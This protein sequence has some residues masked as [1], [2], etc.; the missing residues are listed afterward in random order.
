MLTGVAYERGPS[1]FSLSSGNTYASRQSFSTVCSTLHDQ[2][3][4]SINTGDGYEGW[5]VHTLPTVATALL[6]PVGSCTVGSVRTGQEYQ[7]GGM[8]SEDVEGTDRRKS[9]AQ[10]LLLTEPAL[11]CRLIDQPLRTSW[12]SLKESS[13]A[14]TRCTWIAFETWISSNT[15][16]I[17]FTSRRWKSLKSTRGRGR[18]TRSGYEESSSSR[19]V[20][21][22]GDSSSW[23]GLCRRYRR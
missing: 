16:S 7:V 12:T 10:A 13:A 15:I 2:C 1:C 22:I 3:A 4:V 17:D 8:K 18:G 20:G 19:Y 14:T 6:A 11:L 9:K 21:V 5:K 23:W